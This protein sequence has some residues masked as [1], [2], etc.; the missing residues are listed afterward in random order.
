MKIRKNTKVD[1]GCQKPIR[2]I[3]NVTPSYFTG[4]KDLMTKSQLF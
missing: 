1:D 4:E 3:S 2:R